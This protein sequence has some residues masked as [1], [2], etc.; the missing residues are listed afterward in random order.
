[1]KYRVIY[2]IDTEAN[3]PKEAALEVEQILKDM[4]YRPILIVRDENGKCDV[5]DLEQELIE[6]DPE[7]CGCEYRGMN[8]WSCGHI[9]GE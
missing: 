7:G 6:H 3:T 1:M 9:D 2:E 5:F 4:E 8:M